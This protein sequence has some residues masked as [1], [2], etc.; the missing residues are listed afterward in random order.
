MQFNRAFAFVPSAFRLFWDRITFSRITI[1]YFIFS[2]L[3]CIIQVVFQAQAFSINAQAASFLGG[4]IAQGN[5]STQGFAVLGPDLRICDDVPNT[6]SAS[7]CPVAW[8]DKT[9]N[10]AAAAQNAAQQ[11]LPDY[12]LS[13]NATSTSPSSSISS[14]VI[15]TSAALSSSVRTTTITVSSTSPASV[16]TSLSV[17]SVLLSSSAT[18]LSSTVSSSVSSQATSPSL[19]SSS[20]ASQTSSTV[21]GT[22][23]VTAKSSALGAKINEPTVSVTRTLTVIV[24]AASQ[25]PQPSAVVGDD[26]EDDDEK[27]DDEEEDDDED[28]DNEKSIKS[29]RDDS[30][31]T[32]TDSNGQ[33]QVNL[34][35]FEGHNIISLSNECL[36]ALN[37]P[38]MNVDNTK[39]EDIV[40]ICFQVWVLGMSLVALLN[41]SIPHIF[42][43]LLTHIMAT[44]WGGFQ[45]FSTSQFR[46]EFNRLSTN[47]ACGI[48]L[49][50]TYWKDRAHAEIPSLALNI[51]ALLISA[52][53]TWR[54]IK[55]FGWQTFKRVGA[56]LTVNR[57]YNFVLILSIIIQLCLFFIVVA[58]GLWLDQIY[59]GE[60]GRLSTRPEL[61]K[62]LISL[63][64]VLL[65]PWLA[66]GWI[67]VRRE[68]KG[69]MHIFL[70]LSFLYLVGF[71]AMFAAPTFRWT[72]V[73]WDFFGVMASASVFLTF[74]SLVMGI[75]C[76][77]NFGKGLARY[78]NGQEE[79][80]DD[81]FVPVSFE[82]G[83]D[84]EKFEFPSTVAPIPTFS[85]AFGTGPEIPPPA[86]SKFGGFA[87][88]TMG[89]RFFNNNITPFD[90]AALPT[91]QYNY[92][93]S[94]PNHSRSPT[95]S[96]SISGAPTSW[97]QPQLSLALP[98]VLA[99]QGSGSSHHSTDSSSSGH[100]GHSQRSKR[101]I[102]E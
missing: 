60:I 36:V 20:L 88:R 101:W 93:A 46:N 79:L 39:R 68:I 2:L 77:C 15:A 26:D 100:S 21:S 29:K 49:L 89:P 4:I 81:D 6:L 37:W 19:T 1:I 56:S 7:S 86:Q 97:N 34:H 25:T 55:L 90:A 54:L 31:V 71:S 91:L 40:F 9:Q 51:V 27:D 58:G 80:S 74:T 44:A 3:H 32:D 57:V 45:I 52:F 12:D 82:K 65:I 85:A 83:G 95:S 50:P 43:S 48:N 102:I 99:R 73:T 13:M 78:L 47:G 53:L 94:G 28:D 18:S 63:V 33:V 84:I 76:R 22:V 42:A 59:H 69:P 17:S 64:F 14:S 35:G 23:S 92:P 75:I 67:S 72:W 5:A 11:A 38:V 41:E 61:H 66:L 30:T 87:G 62:G 10:N 24:K 8:A 70:F 98:P 96:S 16:S